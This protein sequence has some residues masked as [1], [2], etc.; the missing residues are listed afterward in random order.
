M[1]SLTGVQLA[2]MIEPLAQE[3]GNIQR[4][5]KRDRSGEELLSLPIVTA[6]HI[7]D[8]NIEHIDVDHRPVAQLGDDLQPML[9]AR[10]R[11][12][13]IALQA[14]DLLHLWSGPWNSRSKPRTK[15]A[16]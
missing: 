9:V 16:S 7:G 13:V 4:T 3:V 2:D 1:A 10:Q 8:G 12:A 11:A 15:M 6:S 5:S 14:I